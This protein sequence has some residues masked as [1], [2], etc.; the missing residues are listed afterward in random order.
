MPNSERRGQAK[1]EFAQEKSLR[2][3]ALPGPRDGWNVTYRVG[4]DSPCHRV[5]CGVG[6]WWFGCSVRCCGA[7]EGQEEEAQL[8]QKQE[9]GSQ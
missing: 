6:R 4:V 5:H 9:V 7:S 1:T 3:A 2:E 8:R